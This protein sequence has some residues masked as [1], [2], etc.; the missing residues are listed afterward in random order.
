HL[1][2]NRNSANLLRP[3]RPAHPPASFCGTTGCN[4][5]G[6]SCCWALIHTSPWTTARSS[7]FWQGWGKMA[8]RKTW[9]EVSSACLAKSVLVV[10]VPLPLQIRRLNV[11]LATDVPRVRHDDPLAGMGLVRLPD[12]PDARQDAA[13]ERRQRQQPRRLGDGLGRGWGTDDAPVTI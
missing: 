10:P 2:T 5:F 9:A 6:K 12:Q 7:R 4:G 1:S 3:H 8:M 11:Q 13:P